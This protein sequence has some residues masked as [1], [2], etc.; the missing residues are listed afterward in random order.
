MAMV[1]QAQRDYIQNDLGG[2]KVGRQSI[3]QKYYKG[4]I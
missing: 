2:V 3:L 1:R 4:M